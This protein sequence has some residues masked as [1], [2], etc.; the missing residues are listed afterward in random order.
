MKVTVRYIKGYDTEWEAA[1]AAVKF[2]EDMSTR[3]LSN[4]TVDVELFE[5]MWWV[6]T[7]TS[8]RP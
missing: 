2:V 8:E 1:L 3:D 4:R 5:G 6:T 7:R